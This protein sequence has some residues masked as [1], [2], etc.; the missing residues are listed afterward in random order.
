[1]TKYK[2][3]ETCEEHDTEEYVSPK[4]GGTATHVLCVE[5]KE[6]QKKEIRIL[7]NIMRAQGHVLSKLLNTCDDDIE[8]EFNTMFENKLGR[9]EKEYLDR[10]NS[11]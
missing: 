4:L 11:E 1:M 9:Y 3:Y 6:K 5:C 7:R 8:E 10:L 2:I